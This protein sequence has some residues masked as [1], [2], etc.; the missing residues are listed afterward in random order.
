VL[1]A[2]AAPCLRLHPP[3]ADGGLRIARTGAVVVIDAARAQVADRFADGI[4]VVDIVTG[5]L[6]R[7]LRAIAATI[8]VPCAIRSEADGCQGDTPLAR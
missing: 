2:Q 6:A 4:G 7:A 5:K 8:A 1:G 3:H